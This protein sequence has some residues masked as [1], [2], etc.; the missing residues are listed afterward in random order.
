[1]TKSDI[2]LR[3]FGMSGAQAVSSIT[4]VERRTG[5]EI[6]DRRES[7]K[8]RKLEGFDQFEPDVR[9]NALEMSE[10]YEIFFCLEV[11]IRKLIET[12]LRDAE[13]AGWWKSGRIKDKFRS[14]V[15]DL[16]QKEVENHITPRSEN[17]LDYLTFGQ[18]GEIINENFDL[19]ETILASR[20]AVTRIMQQLNQIRN[21]IAHCCPLAQDEKDRLLL[22]VKDWFRNLS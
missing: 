11:S 22:A 10:Y 17:K 1:M 21:P 5:L 15:H 3:A 7:F 14:D 19:F 9:L 16:I 8:A 2:Y 20:K 18:L 13:G 4:D 12:T 6:L